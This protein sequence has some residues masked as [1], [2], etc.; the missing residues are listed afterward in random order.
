MVTSNITIESEAVVQVALQSREG[1]EREV[2]TPVGY[3]DLVTDTEVIEIKHVSNWKDGAKIL[4]Y[5]PYLGE[6]QPRIHLFGGYTKDFRQLVEQSFSRLS[7]R[8]T[9]ERE[10]Y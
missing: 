7:V 1:G 9:W 4:L 8:V 10:P 3:V 5:A 2:E 6:R